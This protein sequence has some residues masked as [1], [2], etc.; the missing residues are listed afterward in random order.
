MAAELGSLCSQ[1]LRILTGMKLLNGRFLLCGYK[2]QAFGR[3]QFSCV[4]SS[5]THYQRQNLLA[6]AVH[7]HR[8]AKLCIELNA[9]VLTCWLC[10]SVRLAYLTISLPYTLQVSIENQLHWHL[11]M[12]HFMRKL[13]TFRLSLCG[14]AFCVTEPNTNT[15]RLNVVNFTYWWMA[16]CKWNANIDMTIF[17]HRSPLNNHSNSIAPSSRKAWSMWNMCKAFAELERNY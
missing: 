17:H 1:T 14:I 2:M 3:L 12:Q 11:W 5:S 13:S 7:W 9:M 8:Q 4:Y 6:P 10:R 16:G 15:H